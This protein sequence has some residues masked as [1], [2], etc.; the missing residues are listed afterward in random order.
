MPSDKIFSLRR[1][2]L[3]TLGV[4][5]LL[6]AGLAILRLAAARPAPAAALDPSIPTLNDFWE[7]RARWVLEVPDTG[8]P[9][10]ESD[11]LA[12]GEGVYWSYLHASGPSAGVVDS[13]GDPVSFPGCITQWV[14]TDGGKHFT[15]TEPQ[16]LMDCDSCPCDDD[17]KTWQQQYPRVAQSPSGKFYMV[18]EH[19]AAAWITTSWDGITWLRPRVIPYTGVWMLSEGDC[20]AAQRIGAHPFIPPQEDDCMA[21]GPPGIWIT[22]SRIY[23]FAGF[24]QNPGHLGCFWSFLMDRLYFTRC[25]TEPLIAGAPEYGPFD[26]LGAAAN[27]YFDFRYITSADVVRVGEMHYM[28]YEGIR[29]PDSWQV[30]G[31][32][33][34]ALGLARSGEID[35]VWE[36][37]LRNPILSDVSGHVGIGHADLVIDGGI[38]YLYTGTPDYRRGRYVLAWNEDHAP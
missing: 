30:G 19:G 9:V 13:C 16:C 1:L 6:I 14:S 11:T 38:T 3:P 33:Q 25:S 24:G 21:G 29:G 7:G 5:S 34:F 28:V 27:P 31:D 2:V 15:L 10:G 20:T 17:D 35:R 22:E 18:F 8:L 32:N 37:Y 26:A 12:M 23:V 36:E 4:T